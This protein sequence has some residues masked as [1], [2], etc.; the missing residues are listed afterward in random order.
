M[1]QK[2]SDSLGVA[3][4]E[5]TERVANAMKAASRSY[6][7]ALVKDLEAAGFTGLT[8]ST[9]SLLG[10]IPDDGV[11]AVALARSVGHSKQAIA[12]F[13]GELELGGYVLRVPDPGDKRAQLILLTETGALAVQQ[14]VQIKA[15]LAEQAIGLLGSEAMERLHEDLNALAMLLSKR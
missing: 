14:G 3:E 2:P 13:I 1:S 8:P 7:E 15:N 4:A 11:Q 9:V 6:V 10:R 12:K 5:L